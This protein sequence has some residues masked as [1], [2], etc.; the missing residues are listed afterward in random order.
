M[1]SKFGFERVAA[2][3]YSCKHTVVYTGASVPVTRVTIKSSNGANLTG[4]LTLY[5]EY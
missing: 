1:E 5:G 2:G 4:E 3:V